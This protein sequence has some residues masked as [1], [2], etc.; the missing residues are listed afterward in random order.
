V[1]DFLDDFQRAASFLTIFPF[2]NSLPSDPGSMGRSMALFP[3]VGLA[4]GLGLVIINSVLSP[5]I[6]RPVLDC[7]LI[8]MLIIA[9]GAL[10]LDGIADLV[11]GLAGGKDREGVLRI[12]KDSHVGA[13][14]V[15]GLVMVLLLKYL[16]LYNIPIEK[17]SA[18]LL[19]TPAAGR[20]SQVV[21]AAFCQYVR[22]EGGTGTAFVDHAGEREFLIGTATLLAA[23]VI[24]FGL[25]SIALALLLGIVLAAMIR[26][27]ESRLGGVTGDVLGASSELIEVMT[28]IALLAL[29]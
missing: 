15:V 24:L 13:I 4:M 6:P 2:G 23:A 19:F 26:Y 12:M 29:Y 9:T 22:P 14:G 7:L 21:L 16:S 8:L 5:L 27:F 18:A 3:A 25:K 11:D 28:L 20:W 17:K 10:H 1:K